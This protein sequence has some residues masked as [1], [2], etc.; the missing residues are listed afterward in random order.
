MHFSITSSL[1]KRP[2]VALGYLVAFGRACVGRLMAVHV[3]AIDSTKSSLFLPNVPDN[4]GGD[5][6]ENCGRE[7]ADKKR[8]LDL[9]VLREMERVVAYMFSG[10]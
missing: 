1:C 4:G 7:F 8:L 3:V 2:P 5:C 6:W 10:I 9:C